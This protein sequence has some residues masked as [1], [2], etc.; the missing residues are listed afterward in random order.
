MAQRARCPG[1]SLVTAASTE[2]NVER[3]AEL[4]RQG[5]LVAFPTETVYGLGADALSPDACARIF[6]VKRRPRFDPLIVHVAEAAEVNALCSAFDERARAL[7]A[8][9]WP[10]PLTL[11][12]PKRPSVPD[13]VTSGLPTVAVRVPAHPV[14]RALLA[15]VDR[16]VAAPSANV[17]GYI[18]PTCAAHVEAQIGSEIH[19]ILD[20]GACERGLE[21]TIVDL[22]GEAPT[23]LR[24]GALE[25]EAL[26]RVIGPVARPDARAGERP[27]A[28]GQ[29]ERHYSPHT[30]FVLLSA[31]ATE[32]PPGG[33]VGLVAFR[34]PPSAIAE[35]YDMV[36]VLSDSGD[37]REAASRLFAALHRLD[38][39]GLD[40]IFAEPV[41]LTGV[42][43][44]IAD[45]LRRAAARAV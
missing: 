1:G 2:S 32:R 28:P 24:A 40:A 44:A 34:R 8:A 6:A 33:R 12:L 11:V 35:G 21:S 41:P 42:G 43:L 10:G 36:E 5:D 20:G 4:L 9:F 17:F 37:L 25:L 29:L 23:L 14:A 31:P 3:A 22:S 26:E 15:A 38:G 39:A 18:S 16:P 30:R 13:I 27:R 19:L 7:A 45:R